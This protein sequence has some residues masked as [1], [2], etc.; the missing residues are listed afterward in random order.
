MKERK[1]QNRLC[2]WVLF[3]NNFILLCS[4]AGRPCA[5]EANSQKSLQE[6]FKQCQIRKRQQPKGTG[7]AIAR[8]SPE[9]V[10]ILGKNQQNDVTAVTTM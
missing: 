5:I 10:H 4:V 9:N 6:D 7:I 8:I 2:L 3:H 1:L